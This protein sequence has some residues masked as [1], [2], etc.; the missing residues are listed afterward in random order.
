MAVFD[1]DVS[2]HLEARLFQRLEKRLAQRGLHRERAAAEI[3]ND[4]HGLLCA[5]CERTDQGRAAKTGDEFP[6]PHTPPL[7]PG[8]QIVT[9]RMS[10][11][12]GVKAGFAATI[13]DVADV[14]F[15]SKVTSGLNLRCLLYPQ[16]QTWPACGPT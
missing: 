12:V 4:R 7:G 9:V 3:S 5:R 10:T 13:R 11:L 6:S 2:A 16:K 15:G 14:R 8:V 1:G